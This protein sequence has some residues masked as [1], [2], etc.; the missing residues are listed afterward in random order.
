MWASS[1]MLVKDRISPLLYL[2]M[3]CVRTIRCVWPTSP[4]NFRVLQEFVVVM[5]ILFQNPL[6]ILRFLSHFFKMMKVN[7]QTTVLHSMLSQP[8]WDRSF[9]G[10]EALRSPARRRKQLWTSRNTWEHFISL[11]PNSF[12][13]SFFLTDHLPHIL[14]CTSVSGLLFYTSNKRKFTSTRL[15]T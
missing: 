6:V 8:T 1:W 13:L 15:L 12:L 2:Y 9:F 11:V 4:I 3:W 5:C 14:C 10:S 7:V